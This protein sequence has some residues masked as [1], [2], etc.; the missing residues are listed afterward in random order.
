MPAPQ[1]ALAAKLGCLLVTPSYYAFLAAPWSFDLERFTASYVLGGCTWAEC[2][3]LDPQQPS[4][5]HVFARCA[6]SC[7]Y[8]GELG[9]FV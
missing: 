3:T 2:F 1:N 7:S 4:R 6:A 5:L 9:L 8:C